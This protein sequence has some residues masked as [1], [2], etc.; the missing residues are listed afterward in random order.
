[1]LG[2][3]RRR[4]RAQ[5]GAWAVAMDRERQQVAKL[6]L[7]E[8]MRQGQSWHAA[9][10]V[11]ELRTSRT[12]AYRLLRRAGVEGDEAAVVDGRHGHPA[13]VRAPVQAWLVE[14]YQTASETPSRVVQAAVRE[15]FGL[16]VSISQLNRVR[17]ALSV[18]RPRPGLG[19]KSANTGARGSGQ[20]A[21]G[22]RSRRDGGAGHAGADVAERAAPHDFG[23]PA[24]V[25]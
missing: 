10:A 22:G 9:A 7:I 14:Q 3:P 1:M 15:H 20:P 12:A 19:G 4:P 5:K 23:E 6:R 24:A 25:A 16:E 17:A 8:G 21:A 2:W 11:A 18:G 13:K